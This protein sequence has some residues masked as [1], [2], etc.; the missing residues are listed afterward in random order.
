MRDCQTN[1]DEQRLRM[2]DDS[3]RALADKHR[4][5]VLLLLKDCG[6][7]EE[8]PVSILVAQLD[9]EAEAVLLSLMHQHLPI[10]DEC[11]LIDWHRSQGVIRR[12]SVF[13]ETLPLLNTIHT[14]KRDLPTET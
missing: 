5:Q 6:P 13:E 3:L 12:G 8:V 4:R 1:P 14:V 10:L 11:D 2:V 7:D 9:G